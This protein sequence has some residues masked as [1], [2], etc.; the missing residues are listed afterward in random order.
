MITTAN[1]YVIDFVCRF[2]H[3]NFCISIGYVGSSLLML[4]LS[5]CSSAQGSVMHSLVVFSVFRVVKVVVQEGTEF[6]ELLV[7][8]TVCG[9]ML[10]LV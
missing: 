10:H 3:V 7:S 1:S 6:D 5:R 9:D 2:G 4:S 8:S